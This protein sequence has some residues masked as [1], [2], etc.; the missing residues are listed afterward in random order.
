MADSCAI[1][2]HGFA[3]HK[4]AF[5]DAQSLRYDWPLSNQPSYCAVVTHLALIT[6]CPAQLEDFPQL[7]IMR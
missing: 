4:S 3:V 5:R 7:G 2:H 6:P 1:D